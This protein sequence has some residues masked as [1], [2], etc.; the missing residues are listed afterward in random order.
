MLQLT[1]EGKILIFKTLAI[2][3]VVHLPLLKDVPSSTIAQLERI[4]K[5]FIWKNGNP[6][7]KHTTLC[8][9]YEQGGLKN[10]DIFSKISSLQCS[11][12]KRL[13]DNS[14]RIWNVIPLLLIKNHPGENF[15]FHSNVGIKQNVVKRF[16]KFYQEI[17]TRWEEYLSSPPKVLSAVDPQFIWYNEYIKI[18]NYT[19][20]NC[21]FSQ[22]D[23]NHIGDLF[24]NNGKM[25][26]WEDMRTK[27]GLDD[28]KNFY[29][30]QIIHAIPRAWKEIF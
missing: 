9:E 17:L 20:Y 2:S 26:S 4:Q 16:P 28:N 7:L 22:K 12:V 21:Y 14:F 19:I 3:K 18:D 23:L 1:I 15:A 27:L 8:N 10:V 6:K 30:R 5:H 29:W 24:E 25:R 11:W 13:Y